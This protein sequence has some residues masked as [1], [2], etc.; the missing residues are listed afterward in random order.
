MLKK[1]SKKN[2]VIMFS[3][4][5]ALFLVIVVL[6]TTIF[7]KDAE[8]IVLVAPSAATIKIDGH[9]VK[10]GRILIRSGEHKVVV[11]ADGLETKEQSVS[12]S[13]G[14]TKAL[15]LYL[16]DQNNSFDYYKGYPDEIENLALV[17]DS[18][19]S[20]KAVSEL[21]HIFTIKELLPYTIGTDSGKKSSTLSLGSKDDCSKD[22]CLKLTD[23]NADMRKQ[24]QK[25][26]ESL[27][28]NA[29]DYE[30]IYERIDTIEAGEL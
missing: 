29:E 9:K 14:E 1:L 13:K 6:F 15:N 21:R 20:A 19:E 18:D 25:E 24:M 17:S 28:Y 16:T 4:L 22:F 10:N 3:G 5:V 7:K 12:I 30:I 23:E 2:L 26:I 11:S 27:G 8:L